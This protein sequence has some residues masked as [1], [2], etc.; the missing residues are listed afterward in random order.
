SVARLFAKAI[1]PVVLASARTQP[2][3]RIHLTV[4]SEERADAHDFE[5]RVERLFVL[6]LPVSRNRETVAGDS[7]HRARKILHGYRHRDETDP[8]CFAPGHDTTREQ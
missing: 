7:V 1:E 5:R 4:I 3:Q 6:E 8:L 2:S